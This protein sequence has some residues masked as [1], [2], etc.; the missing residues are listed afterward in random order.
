MLLSEIKNNYTAELSFLYPTEEIN[1][2]FKL[3]VEDT[4]G[5]DQTRLL[6]ELHK[7]TS[8]EAEKKM[9]QIL[10]RLVSTEPIQYVLGSCT[11]Y[12]LK[13]HVG[14]GVLIPRQETEFLTDI[15]LKENRGERFRKIIDLCTGSGCIAIALKKNIAGAEVTGVDKSENALN[16]ARKNAAALNA[17]V[18]FLR[19]DLLNPEAYYEQYDLIVSNPPYV[20]HSE[21]INMHRNVLAWEPHEALFVDDENPLVFYRAIADFAS[22]HLP[23]QG[24][25]YLEINE[26]LGAATE[27]IFCDRGFGKVEI[28]IDLNNKQR[29]IRARF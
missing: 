8:L 15:I 22:D 23:P 21:K 9:L 16:W 24:K 12:D 19:D 14:P 17:N 25:C 26:Q 5:I 3:V 10:S 29:Y 2:I 20:R 18:T 13:F 1:S 6:S 11:F 7:N 28:L 27:Q 4:L